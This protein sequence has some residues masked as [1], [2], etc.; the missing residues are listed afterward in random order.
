MTL[1]RSALILI[2]VIAF[3]VGQIWGIRAMYQAC[4]VPMVQHDY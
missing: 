3:A 2:V 4:S 1:S